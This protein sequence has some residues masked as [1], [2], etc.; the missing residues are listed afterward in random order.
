M[1]Q[2][3]KPCTS[4]CGEASLALALIIMGDNA[5]P[6]GWLAKAMAILKIA[7]SSTGPQHHKY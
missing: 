3:K 1:A 2:K 6:S 5:D 4:H 7:E